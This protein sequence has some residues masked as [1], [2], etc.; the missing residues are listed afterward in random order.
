[1]CFLSC[2][3]RRYSC[4]NS[5]F[6]WRSQGSVQ[7]V[8]QERDAPGADRRSGVSAENIDQR[9]CGAPSCPFDQRIAD[10]RVAACA[11][12]GRARCAGGGAQDMTDLGPSRNG[13]QVGGGSG[14]TSRASGMLREFDP[15]LHR[16]TMR[17]PRRCPLQLCPRGS[18]RELP[19]RRHGGSRP[20]VI[21]V[22][23]F[24]QRENLLGALRGVAG[25]NS[26]FVHGELKVARYRRHALI[27]ACRI[28]RFTSVVRPAATRA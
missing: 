13:M 7:D 12:L 20:W 27:L 3:A 2:S 11:Q 28:A 4:I 6:A 5:E 8:H 21:A 1:M 10:G 14:V 19:G 24:E 18:V 16:R 22:G 25:H 23:P 17:I 15:R 26:Q 9:G